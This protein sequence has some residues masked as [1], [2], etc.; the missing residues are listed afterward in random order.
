M[1]L[2]APELVT[3][4]PGREATIK[5]NYANRYSG[6]GPIIGV[7]VQYRLTA[8]SNYNPSPVSTGVDEFTLR[9]L[10]GNREYGVRVVLSRPGEPVESGAGQPGPELIFRTEC[11]GK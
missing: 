1:P 10:T 6:D 2:A 11:Q 9:D 8:R 3:A 5:L 4:S 7:Y